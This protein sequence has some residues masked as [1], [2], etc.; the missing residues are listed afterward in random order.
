[1]VAIVSEKNSKVRYFYVFLTEKH[2]IGD[3]SKH[4]PQHITLVPPFL[5]GEHVVLEVSKHVSLQ[6]NPFEIKL[7]GQTMIGPK[8]DISVISVKPNKYLKAIHVSLF[9]E[10]EKQNIN[11]GYTRYIRDEF[12]P[13][14]T[15]KKYLPKINETKSMVFDH[16]AVIHKY[17]DIKTVLAINK[18]GK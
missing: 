10:L 14:I 5:A 2:S 9:D 11:T 8:K 1:M 15:I 6:F 4:T 17:K 18:L 7:N 13:H 3:R 16:I 12:T